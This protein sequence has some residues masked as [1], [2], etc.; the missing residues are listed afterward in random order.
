[1][2][3]EGLHRVLL[4]LVSGH[5]WDLLS[6]AK[7]DALGDRKADNIMTFLTIFHFTYK[8]S[9]FISNLQDYGLDKLIWSQ[10]KNRFFRGNAHLC[11]FLSSWSD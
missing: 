10:T 1:M 9:N 5:A 4:L 6:W 2:K 7:V 8:L 11:V 3:D